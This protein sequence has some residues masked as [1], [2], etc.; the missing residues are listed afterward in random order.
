MALLF[1]DWSDFETWGPHLEVVVGRQHAD[2]LVECGVV[3]DLIGHLR[4]SLAR[5]TSELVIAR[6]SARHHACCTL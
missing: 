5:P 3:Q 1:C 4:K 2:R 6:M